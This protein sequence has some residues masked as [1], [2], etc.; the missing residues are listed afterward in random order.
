MVHSASLWG[1][2]LVLAKDPPLG[3]GGQALVP[4]SALTCCV[5]PQFPLTYLEHD[6][7]IHK[8]GRLNWMT[9]CASEVLRRHG[10]QGRKE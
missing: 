1:T 8:M 9:S 7:L 4:A 6:F 3:S 10:E 2:N 5:R